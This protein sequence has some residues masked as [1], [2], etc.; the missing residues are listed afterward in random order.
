MAA[1]EELDA[2]VDRVLG[3]SYDGLSY[4]EKLALEDRLERNLRRARAVEHRLLSA[5]SEVEPEV[6]GGTS[7]AEVLPCGCA[8]ARRMPAG[9]SRTRSCW[10]VGAR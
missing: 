7:L 4:S 2:A 9:A 1:Y 10:V 6:L 8:S 3:L 5:L